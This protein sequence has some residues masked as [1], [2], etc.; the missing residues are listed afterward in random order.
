MND[1]DSAT[2]YPIPSDSELLSV[3]PRTKTF[4]RHASTC[5]AM[6]HAIPVEIANVAVSRVMSTSLATDS[7]QLR[8]LGWHGR[9]HGKQLEVLIDTPTMAQIYIF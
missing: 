2:V 3:Q 1:V 5:L 7:G 4:L 9:N 8:L 6:K